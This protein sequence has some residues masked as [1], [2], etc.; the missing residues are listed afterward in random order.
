MTDLILHFLT[1]ADSAQAHDTCLALAHAV[2]FPQDVADLTVEEEKVA[3]NLFVMQYV[4][5]T[6]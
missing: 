3:T 6:N 2:M 5:V 4:Q 1:T